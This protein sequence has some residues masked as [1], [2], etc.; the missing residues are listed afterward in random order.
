MSATFEIKVQ[1]EDRSSHFAYILLQRKQDLRK[2][3][4]KSFD[5][6][7]GINQGGVVTFTTSPAN[8]QNVRN[9]FNTLL[10]EFTKGTHLTKEI[11]DMTASR[12]RDNQT[13]FRSNDNRGYDNR[14]GGQ[15][16]RGRFENSA[17]EG[18]NPRVPYKFSARNEEQASLVETIRNND[19][20]FGLGPAGSGKTHVAIAIAAEMLNNKQ[21]KKILLARPAKEAGEKLGYLPGGQKDKLDPYMRPLYDEMEKVLGKERMERLMSDGTIELV[22]VGLMRGRTFEDAFVIVD[23]AQNCDKERTEMALTR[24]GTGSKMVLTGDPNQIDLDDKSTSGLAWAAKG[25]EG[26]EGIGQVKL[27]KVVRLPVVQRVVDALQKVKDAAAPQEPQALDK[28]KAAAKG[29]KN[30]G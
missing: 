22:P 5:V 7:F 15:N 18:A 28:P 24:I 13:R 19:I 25:L 21:V 9:G 11:I 12:N 27:T 20:T 8:E 29:P 1:Q 2:A 17:S 30:S 10:R 16:L 6:T 14:G 26:V 3:F 4:E 23:E